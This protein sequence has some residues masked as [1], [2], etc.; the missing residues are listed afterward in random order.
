MKIIEANLSAGCAHIH[1]HVIV[2]D[3]EQLSRLGNPSRLD[4]GPDRHVIQRYLE[5]AC[6]DQLKYKAFK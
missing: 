5:G 6:A 2:D 4:L 3:L 1:V